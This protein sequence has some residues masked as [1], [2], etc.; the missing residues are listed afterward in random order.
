[1]DKHSIS[2][3]IWVYFTFFI[4]G[5]LHES[6]FGIVSRRYSV[7]K[8]LIVRE[9]SVFYQYR[10]YFSELNTRCH[11]VH[12]LLQLKTFV[13]VRYYKMLKAIST[14]VIHIYVTN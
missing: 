5:L 10:I 14:T 2:Q 8:S 13:E 1:M 4:F 6:K 12:T 3:Q 9:G 11:L 7:M